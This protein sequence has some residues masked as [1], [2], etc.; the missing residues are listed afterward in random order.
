MRDDAA[1]LAARE[2]RFRK[3][4]RKP[5]PP[6]PAQRIAHAGGKIVTSDKDRAFQKLLARKAKAGEPLTADQQRA[7]NSLGAAS[8]N[9]VAEPRLTVSQPQKVPAATKPRR[10]KDDAGNGS[11]GEAGRA[12]E[13]WATRRKLL[14]KIRECEALETQQAAGTALEENQVSKMEGKVVLVE[15]LQLLT[16][17]MAL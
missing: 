8:A 10:L 12:S 7:L 17:Q 13:D 6:L 14:K 16:A 2:A 4:A 1:T 9:K 5:P 15:Q 11:A 3:E